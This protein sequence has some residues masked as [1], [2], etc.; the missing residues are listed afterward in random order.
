MEDEVAS[1]RYIFFVVSSTAQKFSTSL[2]SSSSWISRKP[3]IAL[4]GVIK[5]LHILRSFG[6]PKKI[7]SAIG[8]LYSKTKSPVVVGDSVSKS[9]DVNIDVLQ[10]DTL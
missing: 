6:I 3:F 2:L 9:F 7:V 8:L 10:G 4:A 1:S 5:I